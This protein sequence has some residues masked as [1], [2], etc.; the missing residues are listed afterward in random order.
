MRRSTLLLL[1]FALVAWVAQLV[2]FSGFVIDDSFISMR[3]AQHLAEGE[4]IVWNRGEAPVEGF[5]SFLWILVLAVPHV[6]AT[7]LAEPLARVGG[8]L[9]VSGL[10]LWLFRMLRAR[11]G[12]FPAAFAI[13]PLLAG[14]P[15]VINSVSGMETGLAILLAGLGHPLACAGI[16][17]KDA[18][19]LGWYQLVALLACM[20]RPDYALCYAATMVGGY[21]L[22]WR[23]PTRGELGRVA[24]Y[25][26]LPGIIYFA[27]R[28][29]YFGYFL[30]NPFYIKAGGSGSQSIVYVG[31]FLVLFAAP[32]VATL[33]LGVRDRETRKLAALTLLSFSAPVGAY[34]FVTPMMGVYW[35]FLIPYYAVVP[36]GVAASIAVRSGWTLR[37][38]VAAQVMLALST[39]PL[40]S[41]Y[42]GRSGGFTNVLRDLGDA[43]ARAHPE[44]EALVAMNDV[45]IVPYF[46]GWK[47]LDTL[48]LCDDPLAHDEMGQEERISQLAPDVILLHE[49]R[50]T[51]EK[52]DM[53]A[54]SVSYEEIGRIPYLRGTLHSD[55]VVW[56]QPQSP[57][58][59][60]LRAELSAT[61][62]I[63]A[64]LEPSPI[65]AVYE[66]I[67]TVY[68]GGSAKD[69]PEA[70]AD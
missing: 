55:I 22:A 68:H 16:L 15:Y 34:L 57:V 61:E 67:R 64:T 62:F 9:A 8:V 6:I 66:A 7:S 26:V 17:E 29:S 3:F 24:G 23:L 2:I 50:A 65:Q 4:G 63:P 11:F 58:A 38:L 44:G 42:A 36:I 5:T 47:V 49:P 18:R 41:E 69:A 37:V 48:G 19:R 54:L 31:T 59:A 46:G 35:R 52:Y 51:H 20:T 12:D 40:A 33:L 45:G 10:A 39:L 13:V 53:D 21:A 14:T 43:M 70:A 32:A 60:P 30:P 1:S 27:W 28:W 56:A 25:F